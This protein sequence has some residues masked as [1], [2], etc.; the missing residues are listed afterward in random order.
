MLAKIPMCSIILAPTNLTAVGLNDSSIK[1]TWVLP[2]QQ[3]SI[4]GLK[5]LPTV[6]GPRSLARQD[7]GGVTV[8]KDVTE[9][10]LTNLDSFTKYNISVQCLGDNMT[11]APVYIT[12]Y[13]LLRGR[14]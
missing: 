5:I 4:T 14:S 13:T 10:V 12:G 2:G 9:V 8:G 3:D 6:I 7:G 1:V 11:S